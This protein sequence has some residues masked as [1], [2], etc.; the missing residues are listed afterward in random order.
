[1]LPERLYARGSDILERM[2]QLS[3]VPSPYM[4]GSGQVGVQL[5]SNDG[6]VI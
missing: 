6:L 5:V 1:M 4:R 2:G 3:D